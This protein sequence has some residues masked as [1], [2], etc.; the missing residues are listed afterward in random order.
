M[1]QD[2]RSALLAVASIQHGAVA[3]HQARTLGTRHQTQREFSSATWCR[4]APQ[5]FAVAGA[6]RTPL[7]R[8]M[9][10]LLRS[11]P[12]AVVSHLS[13]LWLWDVT[14]EALDPLHITRMRAANG[15]KLRAE[16]IFAHET[17]KMP[18]HHVTC[19]RD[20]P[21]VTPARALV[22]VAATMPLGRV[23]RL[24]DRAWTMRLVNHETLTAVLDDLDKRGRRGVRPVRL[25][26]GQRGPDYVAPESGLEGR[27]NI[28]LQRADLPS[29]RRQVEIGGDRW[30]GRVDFRLGDSP[31]VIEVQSDTYHWSLVSTDDDGRRTD[32][33]KKAG[34]VVVQVWESTIWNR[35]DAAIAAID[36]AWRELRR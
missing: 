19:H 25:L 11:G 9:I 5:V 13:A 12:G 36:T 4:A 30:L 15:S 23:E 32:A 35:P 34:F 2:L 33:M 3:S 26:V 8:V 14:A 21:I 31:L 22:D 17:R 24:L 10:G 20:V 1:S 27:L 18:G 16:R 28:L 29:V 7:Q 6:P